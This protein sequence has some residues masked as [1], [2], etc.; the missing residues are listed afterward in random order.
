MRAFIDIMAPRSAVVCKC[1]RV[2][3]MSLDSCT[4]PV[5]LDTSTRV[6]YNDGDCV[7]VPATTPLHV[8]L[9]YFAPSGVCGLKL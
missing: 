3:N 2:Q 7:T 1:E 5:I 9:F 6:A 4:M 8:I